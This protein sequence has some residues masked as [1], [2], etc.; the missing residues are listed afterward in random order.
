DERRTAGSQPCPQLLTP[1]L[2]N[3]RHSSE[4]PIQGEEEDQRHRGQEEVKIALWIADSKKQPAG[5]YRRTQFEAAAAGV[6]ERKILLELPVEGTAAAGSNLT[7]YDDDEEFKL[8]EKVFDALAA[9][10]KSTDCPNCGRSGHMYSQCNAPRSCAG[11]YMIRKFLKKLKDLKNHKRGGASHYRQD[12][13]QK[14][15]AGAASRRQTA[16]RPSAQAEIADGSN[17]DTTSNFIPH[18]QEEAGFTVPVETDDSPLDFTM[19]K[20]FLADEIYDLHH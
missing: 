19:E 3:L 12:N 7:G 20:K 14:S 15:A 2:L 10:D 18:V 5:S 1:S 8:A 13:K 16:P 17:F 6:E 9:L 4:E 11:E